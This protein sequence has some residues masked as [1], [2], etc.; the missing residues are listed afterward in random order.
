MTSTPF[1]TPMAPAS[2][3]SPC[4]SCGACCAYDKNWPRFSLEAEE[5]LALIPPALIAEDQSGMRCDGNR[6]LALAGEVGKHV[7]CTIY[8]LRP[9]VCRA[10]LPGDPECN[11]ARA[12][13]GFSAITA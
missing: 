12:F 1:L 10:C 11:T 13:Y 8:G 2:D 5:D 4:Q 6:C 3:S 9:D 7:G